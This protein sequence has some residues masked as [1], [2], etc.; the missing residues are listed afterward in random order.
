MKTDSLTPSKITATHL[1]KLAY[2][3]VR[4]S[5]LNQVRHHG[6]STTM[7]Y[8]LVERAVAL[9]WPRPR[10]HLVDDDLGK[11]AVSADQR[12]GFQFLMAEIGLGHVGLVMSLD[13]SRLARNNSDWYRLIELCSMF[14]VLIA[15]AEHLYD[16]R[17]YHDR[18]L[19]GL[20]GMMS[21]AELHHLKVRLQAGARQKAERGA[22]HHALPVG[23]LRQ[24]DGT[25]IL[26][27]DAE[28]QARVRLIFA[29]FEDLGSA[30]AVRDYLAHQGLLVPSRPLHGPAP[31]RT[32]WSPA[33]VSAILQILHN[34]AY[35]GAYMRGRYGTHAE[36][37]SSGAP[38]RASFALGTEA[39]VVCLP[40]VYPA[41]I[42]WE[43]YLANGARLR[44]NR[45]R[46]DTDSVGI[47]REGKA[48]L[49]GIVWCG[50]CGRQMT[51]RYSGSRGQYPSY[52]CGMEAKEYGGPYCQE[53]RGLGLNA[54]VE[55]LVL[56]ALAPERLALALNALDQ[57]ER[58]VDT[59]ERQ[60]HLRLER[61]RYEAQRAQ[62]QYEEVDPANRLVARFLENQWEDKLRLVEQTEHDYE[63]WKKAN[64]TELTL[65]EREEILAIGEDLPRVWHAET[66]TLADRKHLLRLVI[67]A[68]RVDQKCQ[69]G[70]VCFEITW[71]SGARTV[72][73]LDRLGLRY[74]DSNGSDR[75]KHRL[76]QLHAQ[77]Q[78]DAQVAQ[79][80]T[81][82]GYRTAKGRPLGGK[83]V[84]YLR[85][86][87]GLSSEQTG[88]MAA[89]GL[90]WS[91][92]RYTVRGVAQA[93]GVSKSTVHRW[94]KQGRLKG[95]YLGSRKLWRIHLTTRQINRLRK[96][97]SATPSPSMAKTITVN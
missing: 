85:R 10:V 44:A 60:W 88:E 26:N 90:R 25:V 38:R 59:L 80:L 27:P 33:R 36:P 71:Q 23:L 30:W 34:P 19:L 92:N 37:T 79:V 4:Q 14:G 35:A 17:L 41:Y 6:E 89:D 45:T 29:K 49:Q 75:L 22:L 96:E 32:V 70:K 57:L 74:Q 20:S 9:G 8:Q 5:S 13:A 52:R 12:Q 62:R 54:A 58:E 66:T 69:P 82:E 94:L 31:Q 43:T 11:S 61:V 16:A 3:Y 42:S 73:E 84:W 28:V 18:L 83:N 46:W 72:H 63:T 21:E 93:A 81:T 91:D 76:H 64:Y 56:E 78:S 68:V 51:V 95:D 50:C 65:K 48:L 67:K 47:P 97:V 24:S 53:V 87:W 15:D 7:Q 55:Q 2:V 1:A 40:N 77:R 86:L 39:G